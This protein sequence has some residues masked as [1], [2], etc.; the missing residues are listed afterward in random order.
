L[1]NN[2]L[3]ILAARTAFVEIELGTLFVPGVIANVEVQ[4]FNATQGTN[5]TAVFDPASIAQF[6]SLLIGRGGTFQDR[7][8]GITLANEPGN[9]RFTFRGLSVAVFDAAIA[10]AADPNSNTQ[11]QIV[12]VIT[13]TDSFGQI[14][15]QEARTGSPA[16]GAGGGGAGGGGAGGGTV[17]APTI[18]Q[19]FSDFA[20]PVAVPMTPPQPFTGTDIART[21]TQ[22][23]SAQVNLVVTGNPTTPNNFEFT[24]N[25]PTGLSF[26][27]IGPTTDGRA[28]NCPGGDTTFRQPLTANSFVF[29]V[30]NLT[31]S[32]TI[33]VRVNGNTANPYQLPVQQVPSPKLGL[34]V[35][36]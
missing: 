19:F 26:T 27:T 32:C 1:V 11:D 8:Q 24:Y 15:R 13:I 33:S 28:T 36:P 30:P 18:T 9:S 22:G 34:T 29:S 21:I 16:G 4:I 7:E 23:Q 10:P 17:Q 3:S 31:G 5:V 6:R 14:L 12:I 2:A 35:N 20:L 25:L